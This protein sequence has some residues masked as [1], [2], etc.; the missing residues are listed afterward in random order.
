M[1]RPYS[2]FKSCFSTLAKQQNEMI[3]QMIYVMKSLLTFVLSEFVMGGREMT[4]PSASFKH[5]HCSQDSTKCR[6]LFNNMEEL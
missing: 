2:F 4:V 5:G 6:N 3:I 1:K